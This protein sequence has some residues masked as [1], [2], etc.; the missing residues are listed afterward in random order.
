MTYIAAV[1][2]PSIR[3][4][5]F[6]KFTT[7]GL[8]N[9]TTICNAATE[10]VVDG[11][12]WIPTFGLLTVGQV[13]RDIKATSDD[14]AI[15]L[16]GLDPNF[17]SIVLGEDVKGGTCELYRGF[18]DSNN[19]IIQTPTQ[20]FFRRYKG[21]INSVSI[22][23][24]WND[25][26]RQRVCTVTVATNSMRQILENRLSG[27]KTNQNSWQF[28]YPNDTSMNRVLT[29]ASAYFDFGVAPQKGGVA[30]GTATIPSNSS[31]SFN[32]SDGF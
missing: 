4:T 14:L 12:T 20:Q 18:L 10:I 22:S 8:P 1:N 26:A 27:V 29:I 17:I 5:E 30:A 9:I 3:H 7:G 2:T 32:P 19:Q 15:G 6:I 23:E 16:S 13:Q 28:L 11:Y 21:I 31:N 24:D 25:A